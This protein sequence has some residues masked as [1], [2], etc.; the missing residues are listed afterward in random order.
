M[1]FKEVKP[2]EKFFALS[3]EKQKSIIDSA[4]LTFGKMGYKKASIND[5][6]SSAGI[7]K[8]MVF[9]YFGNKKSFY[10]YLTKFS[11]KILLDEINSRFD[12]SISDFFD[13]IRLAT[14]I[15]LSVIKKHPAIFLFFNSVYFETDKD[16]ADDIKKM[17]S[18]GE[19]F[20]KALTLDGMDKSKFKESVDPELVLN[21]LVKFAEG[22]V[23]GTAINESFDLDKMLNE[24]NNCLDLMKNNFYTESALKT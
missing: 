16:V 17:L 19:D 24:F 14:E 22:Y 5:I 23:S 8:G 9:H 21:I 4:L 20:R 6:A 7:S 3:K 18:M 15:K 11:V 1:Q 13:R 10:L 2:L 12:R